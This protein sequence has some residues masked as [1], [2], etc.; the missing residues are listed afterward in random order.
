MKQIKRLFNP[1]SLLKKKSLFFLGPRATGKTTLVKSYK[2]ILHIDLL[3]DQIFLSLSKDMTYLES[4]ILA[5]FEKKPYLKYI[6]VDEISKL[7]ELLDEVHRLI[8]KHKWH[9][10]LT[11]SSA[12]KLK[13]RGVNLLAGRAWNSE[14]FGFIYKEI[15]PFDLNKHLLYGSI[16]AVYFSED[17]IEELS[18][19]C[20]NYLE[21]EIQ[22]EGVVRNIKNFSRFLKTAIL[23]NGQ[24]LKFSEIAS[25]AAIPQ[26]TVSDYYSILEDTLIGFQLEGWKESKKR[27]AIKRSKF[28]FFDTGI[29]NHIKG[30]SQLQESSEEFGN[31]FEHW[32]A[33]EL[34]AWLSYQRKQES[35][36]YWRSTSGIEVDFVIGNH[37]AIEIKSSKTVQ[38]RHL[39]GLKAIQEEREWENLILVT[40]SKESLKIN[41]IDCLHW[42]EFLENLW[43]GKI[44]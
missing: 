33:I 37:T 20:K 5:E 9:F 35:L 10:L 27:K 4:H 1:I 34:K 44:L 15:E 41:G 18:A 24:M 21:K 23:T 7:P 29:V 30:I 38:K 13:R 31:N 11:G 2:E 26:T 42:S 17:P 14:M 8:E 19:Y 43:A 16:P 32:L 22:Q 40:R 25:D 39:R 36:T 6:G 3:N 12:R 28:Y